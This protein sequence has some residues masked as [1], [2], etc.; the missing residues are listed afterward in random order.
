LATVALSDLDALIT[1]LRTSDA[2]LTG[3]PP[4]RRAVSATSATLEERRS[5]TS[6]WTEDLVNRIVHGDTTRP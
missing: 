3:D 4:V 6:K 5:S 2:D 1:E